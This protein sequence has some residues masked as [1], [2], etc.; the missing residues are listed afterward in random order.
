MINYIWTISGGG[1]ITNGQGTNVLQVVWTTVGAQTVSVIFTNGSNLCTAPN[2]TVLPVTISGLPDAAGNITGTA[3]VCAGINDV[4]YSVPVINNAVTYVWTLPTGATIASGAGTNSIT[5]NFATN[6]VS[7]NITVYGNSICGNGAT[8]P[9]YAVTITQIPAAA[10]TITGTPAVCIGATGVVYSVDPIANATGYNWTVPAN[11]NIVAGTN[12][13][14]ITVD[15]SPSAVSGNFSVVGT[16]SCGNGTASPNYAVSVNPIPPAPVILF[17]DLTGE[18]SS[19]ASAGNQWYLE[20]VL[21]LGATS[22]TYVPTASG[23]YTDIVTINGCGSAASNDIYVLMTGIE[24]LVNG[25]SVSVY[26]NPG[27]GLFTLVIST[28]DQLKLDLSV[29]NALGVTIY[30]QKDLNIKGSQ[31][32]TL[33]LRSQPDGVYSLILRNNNKHILKKI[34]INR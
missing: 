6:A 22:Q 12:T 18:L 19:D 16:N 24:P 13:N 14:S 23:H 7:G 17:N 9:P 8:S 10:G 28:R 31:T 1:T 21:I 3:T 2:P 25:S 20:G 30:Q 34:V 11:V 15:F 26:P 32:S 33:D 27:D 4:A 5:V 29:V